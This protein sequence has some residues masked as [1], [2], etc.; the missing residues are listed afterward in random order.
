MAYRLLYVEPM[1]E[2][3]PTY[4][5]LDDKEHISVRDY[6]KFIFSFCFGLI[7]YFYT[8][9][10]IVSVHHESFVKIEIEGLFLWSECWLK[11]FYI[12]S[13]S[14]ILFSS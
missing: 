12:N 1:P 10:Y 7:W 4:C 6:I 11:S 9:C 8:V 3:I 13:V 2:P 5:H 14:L